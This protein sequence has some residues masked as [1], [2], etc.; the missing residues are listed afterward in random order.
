MD[1]DAEPRGTETSSAPEFFYADHW[2]V[3]RGEPVRRMVLVPSFQW[4]C[5]VDGCGWSGNGY[6]TALLA[7]RA[8]AEHWFENH[9]RPEAGEDR[10]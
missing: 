8:V 4:F 6:D 10:G 5:E 7:Q 1:Q 2:S 3:Y 9:R